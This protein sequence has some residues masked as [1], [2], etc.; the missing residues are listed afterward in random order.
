MRVRSQFLAR[1][2]AA[3]RPPYPESMRASIAFALGLVTSTA[4]FA[5]DGAH[6]YTKEERYAG[7]LFGDTVPLLRKGY[8]RKK[9]LSIAFWKC[10]PL[11]KGFSERQ[12]RDISAYVNFSIDALEQ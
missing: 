2:D 7:C 8:A 12:I 11:S 1:L 3:Y 10:E 4:S 5:E 6:I 9:A